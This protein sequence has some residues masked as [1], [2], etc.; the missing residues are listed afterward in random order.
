[1]ET[2][3][4]LR[5]ESQQVVINK[6][7][8]WLDDGTFRSLEEFLSI[9]GAFRDSATPPMVERVSS[10][11][12]SIGALAEQSSRPEVHQ[13]VEA[14]FFQ[15]PFLQEILGQV[16]SWHQDGT[17]E[18]FVH[19]ASLL[20]A[21]RDSV[22]PAMAQRVS[23]LGAELGTLLSDVTQKETM[24]DFQALLT[25]HKSLFKG[26]EQLTQWQQDGTWDSL[27]GLLGMLRAVTEHPPWQNVLPSV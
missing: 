6:M 12:A 23:Q 25:H 5:E 21:T 2:A 20:R 18:T 14:T 26:V 10:L 19:I 1:M 16:A 13:L 24:S 15:G 17:W 22:T 8:Q 4:K 3:Q 11:A 9:L 27:V 7:T